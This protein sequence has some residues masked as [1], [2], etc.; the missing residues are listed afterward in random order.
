[1][2]IRPLALDGVY[3]ICPP[4]FGD[5]RGYF[6]ETFKRDALTAHGIEFEPVQDNES[7]STRVGT[8][9]GLH[10]QAP[11][12]AQSKLVRS[13]VGRI[14][15]V[16]VDIRAQS[17]TY[18]DWLGLELSAEQG[19]QLFVPAGFAHGFMT[20]E[21]RCLIA[22]K[23]DAGYAPDTEGALRWDDPDLAIAWPDVGTP[24]QLS[25]KDRRAGS[26]ADFRTPF[27]RGR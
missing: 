2:D 5:A 21:Q 7:L 3:E 15:D 25:D 16:V 12:Q 26:F 10:F 11:P 19:N 8:L 1:M 13:V 17:P 4:R 23:V 27:D 9:R 20:L 22:Y 24:P 6:C 18:G 14:Y